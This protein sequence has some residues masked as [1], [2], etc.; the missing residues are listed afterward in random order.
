MKTRD[1]NKLRDT[2]IG[3]RIHFKRIRVVDH[4]FKPKWNRKT[5][6][7]IV[8]FRWL[9]ENMPDAASAMTTR[10]LRGEP[11]ILTKPITIYTP[12][13]SYWGKLQ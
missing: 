13:A 11:L 6:E 3:K 10:R 9:A 4:G 12:P 7:M 5:L 2:L 1:F 8:G